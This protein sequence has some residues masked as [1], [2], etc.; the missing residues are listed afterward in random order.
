MRE[1]VCYS[2]P[3]SK[4]FLYCDI[5][6]HESTS[7]FL[8]YTDYDFVIAAFN[9]KLRPFQFVKFAS[10][11]LNKDFNGSAFQSA[12]PDETSKENYINYFNQYS[13]AIQ[14]SK[15]RK[16]VCARIKKIKN[17]ST[18]SDTYRSLVGKYPEAFVFL[19]NTRA[20]GCWMGASP[21][22]LLQSTPNGMK[23]RCTCRN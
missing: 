19:V 6:K 10:I 17:E 14:S 1:F 4:D 21:E 13:G 23:N 7:T 15:L 8:N 18:L 20:S 22:L 11:S 5:L 16:V 9:N 12:L 3:G 2:M